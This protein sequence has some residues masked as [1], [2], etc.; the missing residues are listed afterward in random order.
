MRVLKEWGDE[1]SGTASTMLLASCIEKRVGRAIFRQ[2]VKEIRQV[3]NKM[4][5]HLDGVPEANENA[6]ENV[7]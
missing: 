2:W 6:I 7:D 1:L 3:A 4:E 5:Q